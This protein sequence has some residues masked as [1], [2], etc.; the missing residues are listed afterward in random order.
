MRKRAANNLAATGGIFICALFDGLHSRRAHSGGYRRRRT[1][2]D[3]HDAVVQ[4]SEADEGQRVV[5]QHCGAGTNSIRSE[6]AHLQARHQHFH[7]EAGSSYYG[8]P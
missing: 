8:G 1:Y 7:V 2:G 3:D 6:F 5:Q 4:E